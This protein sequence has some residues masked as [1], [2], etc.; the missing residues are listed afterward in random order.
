MQPQPGFTEAGR[1]GAH[2]S[3]H[4]QWLKYGLK[5]ASLPCMLLSISEAKER[6]SAWT[7][8]DSIMTG[9]KVCT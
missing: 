6:G 7:K 9:Y 3:Q 1:R 2:K 5:V 8:Q 4:H